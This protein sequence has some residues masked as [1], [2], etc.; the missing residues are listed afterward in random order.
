M[1]LD[2]F[3]ALVQ[4][5]RP[6]AYPWHP[7]TDYSFEARKVI[8]GQHPQLIK[9]VFQPEMVVDVGCG[10]DGILLRLLAD[11]GVHGYGLDLNIEKDYQDIGDLHG[12]RRDICTLFKDSRSEWQQGDLVICR[13]VLEHLPVRQVKMAVE[14]M[15]ALSSR[16]VYVTTRFHPQPCGLLD[17]ATS[18]DL[19]PTH[20]TMCNKDFIRLLFVL[21]GFKR[22]AD[23]EARMDWQQKG[24]VLV[25]ERAA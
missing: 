17:V 1:T 25:Y 24:R 12:Y 8:E 23:L 5:Q 10:R 2:Q 15:C 3:E 21:E 16:Y 14:N 18:D 20:I 4:S 19:D 7:V 6:A 22:R 11:I 9:D 13:E